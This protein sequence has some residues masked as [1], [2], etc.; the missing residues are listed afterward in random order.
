MSDSTTT[1]KYINVSGVLTQSVS[2]DGANFTSKYSYLK[3]QFGNGFIK[4]V[5]RNNKK[6]SFLS[7]S[8]LNQ[9]NT[10][11][12]GRSNAITC[13]SSKGQNIVASDYG[14][15]ISNAYSWPVGS[16]L[17]NCVGWAN[18]RTIEL[19]Y[20]TDTRN[21]TKPPACNAVNFID[22]WPSAWSTGQTPKPGA[23]MCWSVKNGWAPGHVAVVEEIFNYGQSDEYVIYSQSSYSRDALSWL[24]GTGVAYKKNNY[25]I[26]GLNFRGFCYSPACDSIDNG[27]LTEVNIPVVNATEEQKQAYENASKAY[28]SEIKRELVVGNKGEIQWLGNTKQDGTGK[29]VNNLNVIANVKYVFDSATKYRH[30]VAIKGNTIGYYKREDLKSV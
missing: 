18:A 29:S 10:S 24:A 9:I 27:I 12:D 14:A 1:I 16:V 11:Y 20:L 22:R 8:N 28:G 21:G 26:Y 17:P 3:S 4:D 15:Y 19:L 30:E 23:V 25:N 6:Y 5:E 2:F 13:S 7:T